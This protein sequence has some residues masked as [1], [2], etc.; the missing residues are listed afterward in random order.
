MTLRNC[1]RAVFNQRYACPHCEVAT[2]FC[3]KLG[4]IGKRM[5]G[6]TSLPEP[7]LRGTLGEVPPVIRAVV[8]ALESAREDL[9]RWCGGLSDDQLNDR[10]GGL[11]SV[12]FHVR[13]LARSA[14]RLV[15]YAEDRKLDSEQ[16]RLLMSEAEPGATRE[17]L[18]AELD[19]ALEACARRIR[20]F[21]PTRLDEHRSVGRKQ[22]PTTVAGLLVHVAD[23]TQRHV[24]Q[25]ITTAKVLG[26]S[27]LP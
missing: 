26:A 5:A 22:L 1:C 20:A 10:P 2:E 13:H 8:H 12:A 9:H 15:S 6:S 16:M 27:P 11:A 3:S 25:A 14:D 24:G 7:W 23:H 17:A 4:N 18:F 21:D 19:A